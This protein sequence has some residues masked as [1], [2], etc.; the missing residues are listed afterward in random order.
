MTTGVP[1]GFGVKSHATSA[2]AQAKQRAAAI[3]C[4]L[5]RVVFGHE[6]TMSR[7]RLSIPMP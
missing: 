5:M 2:Q 3:L 6:R 1:T 4:G 7:M